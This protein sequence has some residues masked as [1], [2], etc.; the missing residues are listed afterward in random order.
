MWTLVRY[1]QLVEEMR[2]AQKEFFAKHTQ[3]ALVKAKDLE[4]K[5]DI[6]TLQIVN[7]APRQQTLFGVMNE[8][9]E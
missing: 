4:R 2:Q 5:V 9:T 6:A 1:A 8:H 3:S 7:T